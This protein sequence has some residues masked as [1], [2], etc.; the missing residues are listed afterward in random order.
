[1]NCSQCHQTE[2][3]GLANFDAQQSVPLERTKLLNSRPMQ[4]D[5]GISDA[6]VVV[7][8]QPER[9][10]LFFRMAKLGRG[11]M[12][13]L[14]SNV[15]DADGLRLVRHWIQSLGGAVP[16]HAPDAGGDEVSRA[17][18]RLAAPDSLAPPAAAALVQQTFGTPAGALQV[19]GAL[20]DGVL[21]QAVSRQVVQLASS[22]QD[23]RVRDLFERFIPESERVQRLGT[24]IDLD[25][26]AGQPGS[27]EQGQRLFFESNDLACRNCHPINGVG[28]MVGPDLRD[29]GRRYSRRQILEQI[30]APSNTVDQKYQIHQVQTVEGRVLAGLLISETESE[31][32]VRDAAGN[33]VTIPKPDIEARAQHAKS[34]MPDQLLR[35]LT[36]QQA[37]DLLEFLAS[38]QA[39]ELSN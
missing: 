31:L 21:P 12:P 11:H 34:L 20:D 2:G 23:T 35:D 7:P 3:G 17:I 10:I 14:G 36:R 28:K 30:V 26:L 38:L 13:H 39:A 29:L 24:Q 8:G 32:V 5:F 27:A 15:I 6:R 25:A 9:S 18:A 16:S 19:L 22:H 33:D 1:V 37:L 4:G